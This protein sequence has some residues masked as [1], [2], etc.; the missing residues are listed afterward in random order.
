MEAFKA[1]ITKGCLDIPLGH[2]SKPFHCNTKH[3]NASSCH[4]LMQIA[5]LS[6][7]IK[8]KDTKW[9]K[10]ISSKNLCFLLSNLKY[11]AYQVSDIHHMNNIHNWLQEINDSAITRHLSEV[12]YCN[13]QKKSKSS[14][15]QYM[16]QAGSGQKKILDF[17]SLNIQI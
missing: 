14:R 7:H 6:Q 4:N 1:S 13:F 15:L 17:K 11:Y 2:V 5:S 8:Q 10:L 9:G 3:K 16:L 12:T